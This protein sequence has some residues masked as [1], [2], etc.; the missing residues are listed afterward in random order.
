MMIFVLYLYNT[1]PQLI[2]K[3][4]VVFTSKLQ[5]TQVRNPKISNLYPALICSV[6][7]PAHV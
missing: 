5:E 2:P 7:I 4:S 6:L 3:S 1:L